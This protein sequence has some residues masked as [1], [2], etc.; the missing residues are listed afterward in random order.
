MYIKTHY[1]NPASQPKVLI[2]SPHASIGER[3]FEKFPSIL[4]HPE[5]IQKKEL[6][7]KYVAIEAD[8]GAREL[9]H[10]LARKLTDQGIASLVLEMD[11]PRAIVDGGRVS[12]HCLRKA[13]P[14]DL[15]EKLEPA[16][17]NMHHQTLEE[18][19]NIHKQINENNGIVIDMHTM[20]SFSPVKDGKPFT[21]HVSFSSLESYVSQF[22]KAPHTALRQFDLITEDGQGNFIGDRLLAESLKNELE[23]ARIE[24]KENDP[25]AALPAFL[26]HTHLSRCPAVA[27]DIPKHLIAKVENPID[28]NLEDFELDNQ[29]I[30]AICEPVARAINERLKD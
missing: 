24:F 5:V 16:F 4:E 23:K 11:Y 6:F 30:S 9:S 15:S 26:M 14:E 28:F 3:F 18:L 20:A 1:P 17:A 7:L 8:R 22:T 12:E 19:S 13:L 21:E 25:Y 10:E 2:C 27:I 29:K